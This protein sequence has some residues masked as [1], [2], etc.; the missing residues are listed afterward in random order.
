MVSSVAGLWPN[1]D[2][3]VLLISM[4]IGCSG[5]FTA[6][7]GSRLFLANGTLRNLNVV[8][9]GTLLTSL[10]CGGYAL[11]GMPSASTSGTTQLRIILISVTILST[12]A[13]A[14]AVSRLLTLLFVGPISLCLSF[15]LIRTNADPILFLGIVGFLLVTDRAHRTTRAN[16]RKVFIEKARADNLAG[17]LADA[18]KHSERLSLHDPLT[19]A[20]NR[21]MLERHFE[22]VVNTIEH[23]VICIDLDR[24]KELNDEYGHSVGDELLV[25][26]TAR[27]QAVLRSGDQLIRSGGD[28]FIVIARTDIN[29][30]RGVAERILRQLQLGYGLSV[31]QVSIGASIGVAATEAGQPIEVAQRRAD[32]A[33]YSAKSGGRN[34]VAEWTDRMQPPAPTAISTA[35]AAGSDNANVSTGCFVDV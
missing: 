10:G 25:A 18:L 21:R 35:R 23:S 33:M 32:Q 3:T 7:W 14:T 31:G 4:L 30:A 34:Q 19:G 5:A 16:T 24:F 15:G 6:W 26:A 13:A 28:E 27:I 20:G 22:D 12:A 9:A 8:R 29:G 17:Q 1:V 11:F 2:H